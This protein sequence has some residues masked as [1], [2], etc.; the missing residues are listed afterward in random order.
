MTGDRGLQSVMFGAPAIDYATGTTGAWLRILSG[1]AVPARAQRP[2]PAHRHVDARRRHDPDELPP[3]RLP[4]QRTHP[5]PHGN[6]HA[7]PPTAPTDRD[8]LLMVGASNL[9]QQRR[10]GRCWSAPT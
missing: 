6:R 1:R 3:R 10:F 8:G 9:R 5:K 7:M 4:A 2:R